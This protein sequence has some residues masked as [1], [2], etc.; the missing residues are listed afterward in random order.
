M[1]LD[2]LDL[3]AGEEEEMVAAEARHLAGMILELTAQ[4]S[5]L[6][7]GEER[8]LAFSDITILLR[9]ANEYAYQYVKGCAPM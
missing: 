9:S 2:I 7:G 6:D 3:S 8:P 4:E 5:V 1:R